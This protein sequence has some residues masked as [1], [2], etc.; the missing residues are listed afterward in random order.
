MI[1]REIKGTTEYVTL[2]LEDQDRFYRV[3][4]PGIATIPLNSVEM[5][6][7]IERSIGSKV[8]MRQ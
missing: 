5:A 2:A 3:S 8:S 7:E 1:N 4:M 6:E